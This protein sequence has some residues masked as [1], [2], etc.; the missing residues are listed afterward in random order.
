MTVLGGLYRC[1]T[2]GYC[3]AYKKKPLPSPNVSVAKGQNAS[4]S[5]MHGT[6]SK[7]F[8]DQ[9]FLI[10]VVSTLFYS[11]YVPMGVAAS[12]SCARHKSKLTL[13][14]QCFNCAG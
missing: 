2:G 5:F 4:A 3:A 9:A 10:S 12:A 13:V 8:S 11:L 1:Q 7:A 6:S 14:D